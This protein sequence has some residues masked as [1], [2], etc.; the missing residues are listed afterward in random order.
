MVKTPD[1]QAHSRKHRSDMDGKSQRI[2]NL[3]EQLAQEIRGDPPEALRFASRE[4]SPVEMAI[5]TY[6]ERRR[7]EQ[8]FGGGLF[9]E[10]A[11]DMMLELFAAA[12]QD[13]ALSTKEVTIGSASPLTTALR[14]LD[15]L[16]NEG[17]IRRFPDPTDKRRTFVELT[18][19]AYE[20]MNV[21]FGGTLNARTP[22]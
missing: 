8:T 16:E 19:S 7:R 13:R 2:A 20:K 9:G 18:V 6:A 12:H 17:I 10:P 4:L 11:W 1:T 3:L 5:M 21:F 14:W 22:N 15:V